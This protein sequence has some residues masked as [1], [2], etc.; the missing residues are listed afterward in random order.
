MMRRRLGS[1]LVLILL[2]W[3]P[4]PATADQ[5]GDAIRQAEQAK[6]DSEKMSR[7]AE[8]GR[9]RARELYEQAKLVKFQLGAEHYVSARSQFDRAADGFNSARYSLELFQKYG[10]RS[11][12]SDAERSLQQAGDRYN[13]AI[14]EARKAAE[15]INS[16]IDE[17]NRQI[18][19]ER[20]KKARQNRTDA[21]DL[22]TKIEN[23][24]RNIERKPASASA[25]S[26]LNEAKSRARWAFG[27]FHS[28]AENTDHVETY[29][30]KTQ[31]GIRYFNEALEI[32]KQTTE[33][34]KC[35][36]H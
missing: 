24:I 21:F 29:N 26:C 17:Y 5:L 11:H 4:Q 36:R 12:V 31:S 34:G 27:E 30:E 10:S 35:N 18:Q 15:W 3:M 19:D 2:A 7:N 20:K 32:V 28:A 6:A 13:E 9:Q 23:A 33:T 25:V 16:G 14:A 1:M 22:Q 8:E